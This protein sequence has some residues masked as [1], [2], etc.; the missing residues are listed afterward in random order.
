MSTGKIAVMSGATSGFGVSWFKELVKTGEF[1][2][3]ILARNHEKIRHLLSNIPEHFLINIHPVCCDL[4]SIDS[5]YKAI[6]ELKQK[7]SRIDLLINNAG[8][9]PGKSRQESVDGFELTFAVNHLA[10]F[11]LTNLL[12]SELKASPAAR[13]V[14]TASFQHLSGK[15]QW[16]DLNYSHSRYSAMEVYRQS[17]LCNVM[18]NHALARRLDNTNILVNCFDPGIVDTSMTRNSL[19]FLVQ[20]LYPVLKRLIRSKEKGAETGVFLSAASLSE[21][22]SGQYFKDKQKKTEHSLARSIESGRR[23]WRETEHCLGQTFTA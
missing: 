10:P 12:M 7:V 17:K 6:K 9:F 11:L 1:E 8:V 5:I 14:N 15:I 19:P 2:F 13:I 20:R 18:F 23:L 21:P 16:E 22:A 4:S 3:Y